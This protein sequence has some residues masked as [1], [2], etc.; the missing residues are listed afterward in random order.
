[1][2]EYSG[3]DRRFFL[4]QTEQED[5]RIIQG[6]KRRHVKGGIIAGFVGLRIEFVVGHTAQARVERGRLPATEVCPDKM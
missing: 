4:S 2:K 1:V 3:A 5:S 6:I